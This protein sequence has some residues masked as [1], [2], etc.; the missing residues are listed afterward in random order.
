MHNSSNSDIVSSIFISRCQLSN[1]LRLHRQLYLQLLACKNIF[2]VISI[3]IFISKSLP[4][5]YQFYIP[6]FKIAWRLKPGFR[7]WTCEHIL[8][9]TSSL[10]ILSTDHIFVTIPKVRSSSG[11]L[12]VHIRDSPSYKITERPGEVMY[13]THAGARTVVVS[14]NGQAI[15]HN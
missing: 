12:H 7:S 9:I 2:Y 13:V 10:I 3:N 11:R 5:T 1:H 8:S 6:I 4:G 15:F 14:A